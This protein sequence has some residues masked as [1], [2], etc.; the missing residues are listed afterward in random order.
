MTFLPSVSPAKKKKEGNSHIILC[1]IIVSCASQGHYSPIHNR[2]VLGTAISIFEL[3]QERTTLNYIQA[4]RSE[5]IQ[6]LTNNFTLWR[7]IP[8]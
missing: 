6:D 2:T 3:L 8:T 7:V 5:R 4:Q 1:K